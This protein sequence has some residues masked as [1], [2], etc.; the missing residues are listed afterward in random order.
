MIEFV[1]NNSEIIL[2]IAAL[3]NV[4]AAGFAAFSTYFGPRKAAIA[5]EKLRH[6]SE[7]DTR[8]RLQKEEIFTRLIEY[9]NKMDDQEFLGALNLVRIVFRGNDNIKRK[10]NDLYDA[11]S[12]KNIKPNEQNVAMNNKYISLLKEIALEIKWHDY[13][14]WDRVLDGYGKRKIM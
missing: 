2:A 3:F 6:Q 5:A 14:E 9:S 10:I 12:D 11:L 4:I 7:A 8:I 13:I 1:K